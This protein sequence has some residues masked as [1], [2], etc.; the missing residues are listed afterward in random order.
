MKR[1]FIFHLIMFIVNISEYIQ[2]VFF[3]SYGTQAD[4]VKAIDCSV[5]RQDCCFGTLAVTVKFVILSTLA[6]WKKET[7][8]AL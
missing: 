6:R 3:L 1:A 4:F 7:L 8:Y 5:F 2:V